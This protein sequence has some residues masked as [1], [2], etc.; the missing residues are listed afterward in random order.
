M[1]GGSA[2]R[3]HGKYD[4]LMENLSNGA[5]R[6]LNILQPHSDH[7]PDDM[8]NSSGFQTNVLQNK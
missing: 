3:S 4:L 7:V 6:S 5:S 1:D 8:S 2:R